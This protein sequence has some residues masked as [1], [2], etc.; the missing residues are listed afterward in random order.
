MAGYCLDR[1][2]ALACDENRHT[3]HLIAES[4]RSLGMRKIILV[5]GSVSVLLAEI[6]QTLSDFLALDTIA[7]TARIDVAKDHVEGARPFNFRGITGGGGEQG[8]DLFRLI[9][10]ATAQHRT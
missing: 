9:T 4:L 3:L 6:C 5:I 8:A 10:E 7:S 1:V 2:Y